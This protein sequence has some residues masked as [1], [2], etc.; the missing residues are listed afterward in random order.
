MKQSLIRALHRAPPL[1]RAVKS[2]V[3]LCLLLRN[4]LFRFFGAR[5]LSPDSNIWLQGIDTFPAGPAFAFRTIDD[6]RRALIHMGITFAEGTCALYLPPQA[7]LHELLG[8]ITTAY[9]PDAGYKIVKRFAKPK[10]AQYVSDQVPW[11]RTSIELRLLGSVY[12]QAFSAACLNAFG[13]GPRC[14]DIAHIAAP[15]A[16]LTVFVSEH[17][18]GRTPTVAEHA[19]FMS[20]VKELKERGIVGLVN[21]SGFG[22]PD[23]AAPD[24]HRNLLIAADGNLSYVDPQLFLFDAAAVTESFV[25]AA[26][27]VL[28]FGDRTPLV[29]GGRNYLYQGIPGLRKTAKRDTERRWGVIQEVLGR[30]GVQL[31]DKVVFD[32]CCN[33]GMMLAQGLAHGARWGVGWDL[34]DVAAAAR[35]ILNLVGAGRS[36]VIGCHLT[37]DYV[38]SSDVPTWLRPHADGAVLFF[39]AAWQHVGIPHDIARLSWRW[40]LFEGHA[41]DDAPT[42]RRVCKMISERWRCDEVARTT[43]SDGL[44]MRRHMVLF[45][46]SKAESA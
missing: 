20:R 4:R 27:R 30:H 6:L 22:S 45:E 41:D 24:C 8:P 40:L 7:G 31:A 5:H 39:L 43:V 42:T 34:P 1:H 15:Q 46:R 12:T 26:Q 10:E 23:F 21:P 2:L 11:W 36:T 38:L 9:P 33:S 37:E 35:S 44:S 17:V 16:D 13:L 28:H 14:Y 25:L 19:S 32:V 18:D 3:L 29:N